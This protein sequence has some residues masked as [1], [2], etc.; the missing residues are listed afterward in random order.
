MIFFQY[1]LYSIAFVYAC[2]FLFGKKQK[3]VFL[4]VSGVLLTIFLG[5]RDI[6][7]GGIDLIRYNMHYQDLLRA[8]SISAAFDKR[9]G[10]NFLFFLSMYISAKLGWSFNFFLFIVAAFSVSTSILFFYRYSNY[11]LLCICIFLPTC[12]IHLFSQL[13]QTIGVAIALY[14]YMLLR[15]NKILATYTVLLVAVLFHPTALVM[16]PFFFL[17]KYRVNLAILTTLFMGSF[18][19]FIFRMEIG[20]LLTA[21]F[22]S[23]YVDHWESRENITGMAVFFILLTILYLSM[24]PKR[25][26]VSKEKYLVISSY[27]YAL[28]IAMSFFFCASYSFAFTRLNN[29]FM[30]FVPL[31]LSEMTEFNTSKRIFHSKIFAYTIFGMIMYVMINRFLDMVVSQNLFMY[32]FYWMD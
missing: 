28:I 10:E 11:P 17:S 14:A 20:E 5:F 26:E 16:I 22:Y 23:Q 1:L 2:S 25:K 18:F 12:Y 24:M 29:Y 4:A 27:L 3:M 19:I 8:D 21:I 30:M 15:N 9:E 6:E 32:R 7:S 31:V 13:K